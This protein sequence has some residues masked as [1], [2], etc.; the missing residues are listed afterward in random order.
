M[1]ANAAALLGTWKMTSWRREIVATGET[2]D[3][4]GPDPVGY[5]N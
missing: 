3:A 4:L 2:T 1:M 5:I